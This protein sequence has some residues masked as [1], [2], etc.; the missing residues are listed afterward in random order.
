[1]VSIRK[2]DAQG[3][4]ILPTYIRE[5]LKLTPGVPVEVELKED[6]TIVLRPTAERCAICGNPLEDSVKIKAGSEEYHI[7][8]DCAAQ[9]AEG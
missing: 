3:R 2:L 6:G 1:M 5:K 7:C 4:V 8:I 9:V